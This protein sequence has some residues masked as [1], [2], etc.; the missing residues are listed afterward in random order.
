MITDE[1]TIS[2][3]SEQPTNA[4]REVIASRPLPPAIGL[5]VLS[6]YIVVSSFLGLALLPTASLEAVIRVW[7]IS[8]TADF[9]FVAGSLCAGWLAYHLA[10][11]SRVLAI[12]VG[13]GLTYLVYLLAFLSLGFPLRDTSGAFVPV[14]MYGQV[15][16]IFGGIAPVLWAWVVEDTGTVSTG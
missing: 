10:I 4:Q 13:Y 12:P 2:T 16:L 15:G 1:S 8:F 3:R 9:V 11:K 6:M 7:R 14:F 5:T